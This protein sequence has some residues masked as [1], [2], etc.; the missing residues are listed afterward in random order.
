ML[1]NSSLF[2]PRNEQITINHVNYTESIV[3]TTLKNSGTTL[4]F[5]LGKK[6][7]RTNKP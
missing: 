6:K 4:Q 7:K 1:K 2:D 3:E 5:F